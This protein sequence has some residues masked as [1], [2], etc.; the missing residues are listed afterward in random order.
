MFEFLFQVQRA[1]RGSVTGAIEG[2]AGTQ[3]WSVLIAVMPPASS[4]ARRMP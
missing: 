1:V 4:S 2:L 3:D